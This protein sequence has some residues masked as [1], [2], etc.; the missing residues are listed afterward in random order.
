[1]NLL[2]RVRDN[3]QKFGIVM[4]KVSLRYFYNKAGI[5]FRRVNLVNVHKLL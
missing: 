2:E 5:T 1:M 4:S 3:N